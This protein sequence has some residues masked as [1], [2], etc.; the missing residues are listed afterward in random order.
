MSLRNQRL[1]SHSILVVREIIDMK[2][3]STIYTFESIL[4]EGWEEDIDKEK[5][6][7]L[8]SLDTKFAFIE[9]LSSTPILKVD[10]IKISFEVKTSI[11][12][13]PLLGLND[14]FWI[15]VALGKENDSS[16]D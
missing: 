3:Q 2:P 16:P 6:N 13:I 12:E 1:F 7:F 15:D 4:P 14:D 9:R 5:N 10:S 8:F 11:R